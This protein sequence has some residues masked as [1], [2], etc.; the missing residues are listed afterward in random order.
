MRCSTLLV[1]WYESLAGYA[2]DL[3][4]GPSEE[5]RSPPRRVRQCLTHP[6]PHTSSGP[7]LH[8]TRPMEVV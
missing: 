5:I 6:L 2:G 7:W 8:I 4:P 1:A 3:L